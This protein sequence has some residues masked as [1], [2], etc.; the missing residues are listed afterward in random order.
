MAAHIP[1]AHDEQ[2]TGAHE[3]ILQDAAAPAPAPEALFE[4]VDIDRY[5]VL[6]D[7]PVGYVEHIAPVFVCYV[8]M[9]YAMAE[10]VAQVHDFH[11]AVRIVLHRAASARRA[12]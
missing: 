5:V 3:D 9:A 10:E 12:L 1:T 2:S 8:G 11:D 7:G 6:H 4:R